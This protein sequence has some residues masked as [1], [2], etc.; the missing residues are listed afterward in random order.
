MCHTAAAKS[1]KNMHLQACLAAIVFD[2]SPKHSTYHP[3]DLHLDQA[4][5]VALEPSNQAQILHFGAI[6]KAL[7]LTLRL[8]CAK[9]SWKLPSVVWEIQTLRSEPDQTMPKAAAAAMTYD[10][11]CI[12]GPEKDQEASQSARCCAHTT[13]MTQAMLRQKL[14]QTDLVHGRPPRRISVCLWPMSQWGCSNCTAPAILVK[15]FEGLCL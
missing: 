2:I 7:I 4:K 6:R 8:T 5:L 11:D 10:F 15:P 3:Y 13:S 12:E 14:S 9:H 1:S